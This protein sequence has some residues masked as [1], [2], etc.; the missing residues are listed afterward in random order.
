[1]NILVTGQCSLHWGRMEFGNIG[2]YYIA[3]PFFRELHRV[4]PGASITTTLQMSEEFCERE[5]IDRL[6]LD[7][8]YGWAGSDLSDAVRD[9]TAAQKYA[10]TGRL[11]RERSG[12]LG[13]VLNADLIVDFSGDIWGD[14]ANLLG[15]NRFSVGVLKNLTAHYLGRP[16]ALLAGSPGPFDFPENLDMAQQMFARFDLVTHRE[17]ATRGV[18]DVY[19]LANTNE[20]TLACPAFLFESAPDALVD[21]AWEAEQL[22]Q[23]SRP[24]LGV[25]LCGWNMP[26]SPFDRWPRQDSEYLAFVQ[27]ISGVAEAIDVDVCLFSHSNGFSREPEFVLQH[28]RDYPIMKQLE[29]LLQETNIRDR[30]L[31]IEGVYLPHIM[32]GI[33]GRFDMLLSGR[34][35]AAVAG[36]SQNVPTV[37]IDYGHEPTA[38]KLKGFAEVAGVGDF[39]VDPSD[40]EA[41]RGTISRCW[42]QRKRVRV[43]LE[44]RMLDVRRLARENFDLLPRLVS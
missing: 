13:A 6:P 36:V 1:M 22:N 7:F 43:E 28:G 2:N 26:R 34:V 23:L 44:T 39:V 35:H 17:S 8:Y 38:H 9:F 29:G 15:P 10:A 21:E 40:A 27:A 42:E 24:V 32:K 19:G 33:I 4:F 20:H 16:V 12:Y 25:S 3:E 14:N 41:M 30:V 18:L 11:P 37:I 5:R 31:T